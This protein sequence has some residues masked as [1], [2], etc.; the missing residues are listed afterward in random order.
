MEDVKNCD[1]YECPYCM[2]LNE[3]SHE[4]KGITYIDCTACH[5][6][7]YGKEVIMKV[8]VS[9]K[10]KL[11][12]KMI[13]FYKYEKPHHLDTHYHYSDCGLSYYD[14]NKTFGTGKPRDTFEKI[15]ES[16]ITLTVNKKTNK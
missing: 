1:A 9:R 2:T 13:D 12:T 8:F 5:K 6:R 4:W 16:K 14:K 3:E 15:E 10:V 7:F 11:P